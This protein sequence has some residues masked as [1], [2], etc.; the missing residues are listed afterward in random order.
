MKC[1]QPRWILIYLLQRI[2]IEEIKS[3]PWFLKNLPSELTDAA[4]AVYYNRENS[5]YSLQT[6]EEIMKI[7]EE[8][9]TPPS[10]SRSIAAFG[11]GDDEEEDEYG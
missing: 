9:R 1:D 4:Q 2:T 11:W 3:H 7:V 5:T 10:T 8:A 6:V